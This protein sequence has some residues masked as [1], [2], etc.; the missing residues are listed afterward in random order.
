M[1][2]RADLNVPMQDGEI[3]NDARIR[4]SL[5]TI[6]KV[7]EKNC[8]VTVLSH[9][10]RPEEGKFD[11]A[12]FQRERKRRLLKAEDARAREEERRK[13]ENLELVKK[14]KQE[15]LKEEIYYSKEL[16][17][18]M[19]I[20]LRQEERETSSG[21][22]YCCSIRASRWKHYNPEHNSLEHQSLPED[23]PK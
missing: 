14:M 12:N 11:E 5:P 18:D 10:G 4:A 16:K 19:Q 3:T 13:R 6:S 7:L 15:Q 21:R 23:G 20:F 17:K 2:I 1:F 9:L 22:R 8:A